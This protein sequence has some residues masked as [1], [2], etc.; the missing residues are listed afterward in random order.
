MMSMKLNWDKLCKVHKS[1]Q[2]RQTLNDETTIIFVMIT[3]DQRARKAVVK[4]KEFLNFIWGLSE[5][6]EYNVIA[7]VVQ[8]E[9]GRVLYHHKSLT[10]GNE[11]IP[12]GG[13]SNVISHWGA[14]TP[15]EKETYIRLLE[16]QFQAYER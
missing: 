9:E 5:N 11:E 12:T 15:E 1:L 16:S 7:L 6:I 8:D 10:A 13:N 3:A 14:L 2:E 4:F